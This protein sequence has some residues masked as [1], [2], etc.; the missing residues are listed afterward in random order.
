MGFGVEDREFGSPVM[1]MDRTGARK[2]AAGSALV[3]AACRAEAETQVSAREISRAPWPRPRDR[4][5]GA[6]CLSRLNLRTRRRPLM[7]IEHSAAHIV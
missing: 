3:K 5:A 2:T 6:V 4:R 7:R 1:F